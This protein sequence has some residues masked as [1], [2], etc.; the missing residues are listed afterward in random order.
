MFTECGS[1]GTEYFTQ[2]RREE[3]TAILQFIMALNILYSSEVSRL[4]G[5]MKLSNVYICDVSEMQ[6]IM[7]LITV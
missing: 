3:P 7:E 4:L 2:Q 6:V 1:Y 5:I